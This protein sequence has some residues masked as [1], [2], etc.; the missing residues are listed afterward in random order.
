VHDVIPCRFK[1]L[2]ELNEAITRF[3]VSFRILLPAAIDA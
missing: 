2:L 3:R 1:S